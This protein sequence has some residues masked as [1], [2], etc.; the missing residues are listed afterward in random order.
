[1]SAMVQPA[2]LQPNEA[3]SNLIIRFAMITGVVL[4]LAMA[5]F[6]RWKNPAFGGPGPEPLVWAAVAIAAGGF[7]G[8][9]ALARQA[10]PPD[11]QRARTRT[12][13]QLALCEP[14]ALLGGIA[15]LLTGNPWSWLAAGLGVFGMVL[16]HPGRA[17]A[18]RNASSRMMR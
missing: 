3:R 1:M 16:V 11:V 10:P 15:W 2:A 7:V 8:S 14:G 5:T 13:V 4:W 6:L 9:R 18:G 12:I 17:R